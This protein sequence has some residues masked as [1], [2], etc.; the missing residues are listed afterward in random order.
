MWSG[1]PGMAD[2][3]DRMSVTTKCEA[4]VRQSSVP[5]WSPTKTTYKTE[6]IEETPCGADQRVEVG[7]WIRK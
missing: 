7:S 3:V 6:Q 2:G 1:A 4:R 5:A